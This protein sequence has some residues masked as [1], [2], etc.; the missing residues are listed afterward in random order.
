MSI[1]SPQ[2]D[3]NT[4]AAGGG[5][6]LF[7]RNG[8][9]VVGPDSASAH[10]GPACY[11]KGGPLTVTDA[12]LFLGRLLP[13]YFPKI[14]GPNENEP[15]GVEI[16][17]KKFA[18]LTAH[19]N[20]EQRTKGWSEFTPEEVALGF[21]SVA[22][23]SMS[24]PIRALTEA[25]GYDT[26]VHHLSCFGGAGGQ[27]ACS[28]AAVLGISRVI[29]HKYSS[30]LSAYGM[31]L[32]DVVHEAQ[33]PASDVFTAETQSRFQ[34]KMDALAESSTVELESQ[35]FSRENI[36]HEMYLHMRHEG[37]STALMILKGD[38]WDFGAEFNKR[39]QIEFGFLSQGKQILVDDIRVRSV[40]SAAK[41]TEKSPYAQ[42]S[43]YP[44]FIIPPD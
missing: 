42:V 6:I 29:I 20:A 19:I 39:H 36:R 34:S 7:W 23:E 26:S 44:I 8:L 35:G 37:T 30:I 25:R 21:L 16:T 9:F 24:R 28:V 4:V 11:R 1:Q 3:I 17:R 27:H 5:S 18:E 38:D 13:E 15:L 43:V 31:A 10:P 12:N 40:A 33:Q 41:W 32:A 14:F 2:L 22:D